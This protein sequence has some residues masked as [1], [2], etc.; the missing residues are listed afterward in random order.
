ML[1]DH[2]VVKLRLHAKYKLRYS[3]F[4]SLS[5]RKLKSNLM[6]CFASSHQAEAD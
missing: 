6:R 4:T 5:G 2:M 1:S 3:D